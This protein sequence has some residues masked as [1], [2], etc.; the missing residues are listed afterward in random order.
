MSKTQQGLPEWHSGKEKSVCQAGDT[1][2]TVSI[3]GSGRSCGVGNGNPLQY[4]CLKN[5]T[6]RGARQATVHGVAES[7]TTEWTHKMQQNIHI[8]AATNTDTKVQI[9]LETLIKQNHRL[10]EMP[11]Q[12]PSSSS[13]TAKN[14]SAVWNGNFQVGWGGALCI[15]KHSLHQSWRYESQGCLYVQMNDVHAQDSE[16]SLGSW[17]NRKYP[18]RAQ[19]L[20]LLGE[21]Q[22][23]S[24]RRMSWWHNIPFLP[25][26]GHLFFPK[27]II[28]RLLVRFQR[29]LTKSYLLQMWPN[30]SN[31]NKS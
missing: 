21:V 30:Y 6:D 27:E 28:L 26:T 10:C 14:T 1:R 20:L 7:A 18:E 19:S 22:G 2:D 8:S 23:E 24:G 3:P 12:S 17:K 5:S 4:S 15:S 11:L 31:N 16:L 9:N 25:N 29:Q 13:L